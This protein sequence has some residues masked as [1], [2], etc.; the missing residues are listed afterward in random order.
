ML[1]QQSKMADMD[2]MIN[3]ISHQW[4]QPLN[5]LGIIVQDVED[6]FDM[7][8]ADKKYL[9]GFTKQTMEL[10]KFMSHTVD[11]FRNFLKPSHI[12]CTFDITEALYDVVNLFADMLN[13]DSIGLQVNT[14][15]TCRIYSAGYPNELKQVILNLINNSR[16]AV[17]ERRKKGLITENGRITVDIK[18]VKDRVVVSISDNGGGIDPS[19][20]EKLFRP[21]VTTKGDAGTGI[22]LYMSKSI[23]E[24]KMDGK[25]SVSN[26]DGGARFAIELP[27][28][29]EV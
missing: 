12:K 27:L 1:I 28:V 24:G 10:I 11:T 8:E 14:P 22:G 18:E 21:Y 2:E 26:I 5:A 6:A 9:E 23:I 13:K 16:D 4:K 25:I 20:M 29:K 19:V 7:G 3:A 17:N 15:K